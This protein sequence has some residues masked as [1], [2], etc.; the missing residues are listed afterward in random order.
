MKFVIA[1]GGSGGHFFPALYLAQELQKQGHGVY[2]AGALAN[3]QERMKAT[4]FPY[5]NVN[6]KGFN[7]K[8][9]KSILEFPVYMLQSILASRKILGEIK[10]DVVCGFG[11]YGSF[12]VIFSA[13]F[14]KKCPTMIHEQNVVP[15][16]ANRVLFPFV[17][18]VAVSFDPSHGNFFPS[19][20]A[21]LTGCPCHPLKK[22]NRDEALRSFG[23]DTNKKTI[24]VLGGSQG[25]HAVN[26]KFMEAIP[27]LK[28][29]LDVQIIHL[30]GKK[31]F[32][33]LQEKYQ[34]LNIPFRLFQF[35][36]EMARAYQ[37][38][39]LVISRSGAVT[40]SELAQ[41]ALPAILIPYPHAGAHQKYNAMVLAEAGTARVIE[42]KNVTAASLAQMISE[43]LRNPPNQLEVKKR[44]EAII[45]PDAAVRLAREAVALK[46]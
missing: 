41:F 14:F 12:P 29:N 20:K 23:L 25:S 36:D 26:E 6:A 2:F 7:K 13:A 44:L 27:L 1:T 28:N 11:G 4:G 8:S 18:K 15:G 38:A 43:I 24:L 16:R 3:V 35:F 19:H 33:G 40:V 34:R 9:L 39:D 10:P 30:S 22:L 5:W 37:A 32:W 42:E 45:F 46:K 21:V 31:D 17:D